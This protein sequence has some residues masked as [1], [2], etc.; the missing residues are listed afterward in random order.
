VRPHSLGSGFLCMTGFI[1]NSHAGP[2]CC[3][4]C[5]FRIHKPLLCCQLGQLVLRMTSFSCTSKA[6]MLLLLLQPS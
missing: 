2:C 6:P 3:C 5:C 1:T 4:C